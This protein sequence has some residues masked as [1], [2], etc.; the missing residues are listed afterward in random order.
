MNNLSSKMLNPLDV[1]GRLRLF[2]YGLVVIT[3]L[4]FVLGIAYPW[5]V[6]WLLQDPATNDLSFFRPYLPFSF[7]AT[8][9]VAGA[10]VIVYFI[11]AEILKRTVGQMK[12]DDTHE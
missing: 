7:I 4:T 3:V 12:I 9:I 5:S 6:S 10:M 8:G 11:Y 2:R 1:E